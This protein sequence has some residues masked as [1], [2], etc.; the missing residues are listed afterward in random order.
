MDNPAL[1][2]IRTLVVSSIYMYKAEGPSLERA[3]EDCL[4]HSEIGLGVSILVTLCKEFDPDTHWTKFK[5]ELQ[6]L[7]SGIVAII[8]GIGNFLSTWATINEKQG[9]A[10]RNRASKRKEDGGAKVV[11]TKENGETEILALEKDLKEKDKAKAE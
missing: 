2:R 9:K 5:E 3:H 10:R 11:E 7:A 1:P 6:M 4:Y 8:M